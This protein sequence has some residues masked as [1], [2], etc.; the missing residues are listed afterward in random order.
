MRTKNILVYS[1]PQIR[2][3]LCFFENEQRIQKKE[4]AEV[5]IMNTRK[6]KQ[7]AQT[8][9]LD[10]LE[11]TISFNESGVDFQVAYAKDQTGDKW[12]LR[13]PRRP[14]SMR[15][16]RKE[17][18]ALDI[19]NHYASFQVPQWSIYSNDL[20]AYKQLDGAPAA[21]I[22]MNQ[23]DYIWT[24]DKSNVPAEY[25]CSLGKAL[26]EL[27]SLPQQEFINNGIE[28]IKSS[29]LKTTM[30]Q[31]MERAKEQY[32]INKDLWERWDVWLA[33]DTLW[34]SH[35]GVT[36][37]DLHPG[38]ILTDKLHHVTGII[39]WTEV[40]IGDISVD[41]MSHLL[42]FGKTGL[43]NLIDAYDNAGGKTWS[44]M[45]EH[46]TELL[47][48]SGITVAEYAQASGLKEM[49]EAAAQMFANES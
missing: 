13:I 15:H 39:D 38:H 25:Y 34:P 23:Q 9:G 12:I 41:F 31:R 46:I 11:N 30:K 32:D 37:G 22:D 8:K 48:T 19:I 27:H 1:P 17:K 45:D 29:E 10:I 5:T 36:H 47:T 43:V 42:L 14:E 33:E 16:A 40:A 6:L 28:M 7:L 2:A 44:R 18:T 35:V 24:F 20:I 3:R 49:Q 4:V 26:A 21:T